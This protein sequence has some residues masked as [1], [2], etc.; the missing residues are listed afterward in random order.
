MNLS[1]SRK[2]QKMEE[3]LNVIVFDIDECI[4]DDIMRF[5]RQAKLEDFQEKFPECD[6]HT[7][8]HMADQGWF[9]PSEQTDDYQF[10]PYMDI[11]MNYLLNR[12][13]VRI[14]FFSTAHAGRNVPLIRKYFEK[15]VG[16]SECDRL[17]AVGQF[18]VFSGCHMKEGKK[19]ITVCLKDNET[20]RDIILVDDKLTYCAADQQEF[21]QPKFANNNGYFMMGVFKTYFESE[22]YQHVTSC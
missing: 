11:V 4:C 20:L 18:K 3:K 10:Y 12:K 16:K 5:D 21:I 2:K 9:G 14:A 17:E 19:E 13:D 7:V 1:D 22:Q 8:T 15:L 6:Y